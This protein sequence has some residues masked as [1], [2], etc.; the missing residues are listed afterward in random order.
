MRITIAVTH[1]H[2]R[3]HAPVSASGNA[4][5]F[6]SLGYTKLRH[7]MHVMYNVFWVYPRMNLKEKVQGPGSRCSP[8]Y[9]TQEEGD[10]AREDSNPQP[11]VP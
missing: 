11:K 10:Y 2:A 5:A 9:P 3:A 4:N 7:L 8:R 1:A 6:P